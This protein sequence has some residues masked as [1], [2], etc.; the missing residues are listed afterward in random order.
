MCLFRCRGATLAPLSTVTRVSARWPCKVV[1]ANTPAPSK[2]RSLRASVLDTY[3]TPLFGLTAMLNSVVPTFWKLAV[4]A[5]VSASMANTSSSGKVNRTTALQSRPLLS[6][7]LPSALA[8]TIKPTRGAGALAAFVAGPLT[9]PGMALPDIV[10]GLSLL[11][12]SHGSSDEMLVVW[13]PEWC[14]A[15]YTVLPSGV[16]ARARGVSPRKVTMAS[17]RPPR[18]L[19]RALASN[20]HTSARPTPALVSCGSPAPGTPARPGSLRC[21]PRRAVVMKAR[22]RFAPANTMSRG[23]SP[24]SSVRTTRGGLALTSTMLTLSDKWFTT[25]TSAALRTATATGS[26]P[27][28][29]EASTR[30]VLPVVSTMSSVPAAVLATN[31]RAPSADSANGRTGPDSK[32]KLRCPCAKGVGAGGPGTTGSVPMAPPPPPPPQAAITPNN[33]AAPAA[34]AAAVRI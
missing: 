33:T 7:H 17:G 32:V 14:T 6:R 21:W 8:F 1:P 12:P 10:Q 5:S 26:T 28:G 25:H 24:T 13:L 4:R 23:S 20:T 29:T 9:E 15:A 3:T 27:T 2:R 22:W 11:K 19:P 31:K 16:A 34:T 18:L 30:S